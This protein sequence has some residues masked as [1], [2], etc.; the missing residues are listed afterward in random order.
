MWTILVVLFLIL[1]LY[2]VTASVFRP[3]YRYPSR[4]DSS[5]LPSK[6]STSCVASTVDPI[7]SQFSMMIGLLIALSVVLLPVLLLLPAIA[8]WCLFYCRLSVSSFRSSICITSI[9]GCSVVSSTTPMLQPA[10]CKT[11]RADQRLPYHYHVLDGST[12]SEAA[13]DSLKLNL[14]KTEYPDLITPDSP[15][16]RVA[17]APLASLSV[18]ATARAC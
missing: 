6:C 10:F 7:A 12:M 5:P 8:E 4:Y 9:A 18:L 2:L 15:T 17:G 3:V 16:Q 14:L 13:A 11:S 1:S